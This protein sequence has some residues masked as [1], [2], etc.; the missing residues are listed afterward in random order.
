MQQQ[1][2]KEE[3]R[4]ALFRIYPVLLKYLHLV[5][6][7][8]KGHMALGQR[9]VRGYAVAGPPAHVVDYVVAEV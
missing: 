4:M 9:V 6:Y 8:G 1:R 3:K 5:A 7:L 2:L